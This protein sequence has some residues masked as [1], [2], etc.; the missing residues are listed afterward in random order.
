M[1]VQNPA[2]AFTN[3]YVK[4]MY[5][6]YLEMYQLRYAGVFFFPVTWKHISHWRQCVTYLGGLMINRG[7]IS[8]DQYLQ[9]KKTV[10]GTPE[11]IN[12]VQQCTADN[13]EIFSCG[14]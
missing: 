1:Q 7:L 11:L 8:R 3:N 10:H 4:E 6:K 9:D 13:K 2:D 12:Q 14:F 5:S